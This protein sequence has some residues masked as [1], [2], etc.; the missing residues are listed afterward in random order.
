MPPTIKAAKPQPIPHQLCG[1]RLNPTGNLLV[2]GTMLGT[3]RRWNVTNKELT[4]LSPLTGHHGWVQVVAFA[5]Q[6]GLLFSADSWGRL[7]AWP[8]DP[9]KT[10]SLWTVEAA[11][12]G[13]IHGIAVHPN[14]GQ[15]ASV[16]R[17]NTLRLTDASNGKTIK[18][19]NTGDDVFSICFHP[20]GESIITGDLHGIIKEYETTTGKLKRELD[21][22]AM[23]LRD[24]IQDTGGVRC[25]AWNADASQLVA[26]G[27]K[28]KTGGFVQGMHLLT[29]YDWKTGKAIQTYQSANDADGFVL[30]LQWHQAGYL[31]AVTSGQPGNGKLLVFKPGEV[32]PILNQ[33]VPNAHSLA[34]TPD[35]KRV[36]VI[37]T[38]SHGGNGRNLGP[39]KEYQGNTSPIHTFDFTV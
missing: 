19:W 25:L 27:T 8:A 32:Q 1:I 3:I 6:S 15:L 35:G 34:V 17:D 2:G 7:S 28:P 21:A 39:N 36:Y 30:D 23:F 9:S 12:D 13:W 22:K 18:S 24:R 26:G 31:L 10:T 14:G 11:H 38:H 29:T 37:G 4:E 33:V 5:A 20:T 16:G